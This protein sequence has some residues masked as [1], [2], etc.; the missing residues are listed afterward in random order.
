MGLRWGGRG[1]TTPRRRQALWPPSA[2]TGPGAAR[3]RQSD[4]L[5]PSKRPR[6][7]RIERVFV[8]CIRL[9]DEAVLELAR[10]VDDPVLATKLE[11]AHNRDVR[12]LGLTIPERETILAALDDPPTELAELRAVLLGEHVA[13]KQTG[14]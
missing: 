14:L 7:A 3:A 13:R 6:R 10:L 12:V 9:R 2:L 11:E 5:Q 8:A 1:G 4:R